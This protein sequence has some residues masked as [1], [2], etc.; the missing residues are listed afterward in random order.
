MVKKNNKGRIIKK[1]GYLEI[2]AKDTYKSG[3]KR[4]KYSKPE[5]ASTELIIYHGKKNV[6]SGFKSVEEAVEKSKEILG[7]KGCQNYNI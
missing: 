3:S 5:V 1:V 7:E 4:G 6:A 2:R